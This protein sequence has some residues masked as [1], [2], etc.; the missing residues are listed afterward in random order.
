[1]SNKVIDEK[2]AAIVDSM[3][4]WLGYQTKIGRK[5]FIHEASLRYPVADSITGNGIAINRVVLE[6]LHPL[7][8]SKKID[9][10]VYDESVKNPD[11][12]KDDSKLSEIYEFKLAK[13]D[14]AELK[15]IEHQRVFDD[16]VRLA[17]YNLW[18]KKECYFLMCGTYEEFKT[19]FVGQKADVKKVQALNLVPEKKNNNPLQIKDFET[20]KPSGLYKDW[21]SFQV[22]LE[23]NKIFIND[24]PVWGLVPF[25]DNYKIRDAQNQF[26]KKINVRTLCMALTPVGDKNKTHAAGIWKIEASI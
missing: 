10:V 2:F 14:T 7:F 25:Q 4:Y 24:D 23:K 8:K 20:W 22:G 3:C 6:K 12:E 9:L 17:Y 15:G 13:K 26:E 5:R 16:V 19:F 21:F 11:G 1:M 18:S